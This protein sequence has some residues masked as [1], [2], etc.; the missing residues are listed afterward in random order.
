[1]MAAEPSALEKRMIETVD[2]LADA[3]PGS[4]RAMEVL[5][6]LDATVREAVDA[7]EAEAA[8]RETTGAAALIEAWSEEWSTQVFEAR[9]RIRALD[10]PH[11]HPA[12]RLWHA[13]A[14]SHLVDLPAP[15][16]QPAMEV[17]ATRVLAA[18]STLP[19]DPS[20]ETLGRGEGWE[21][22][23]SEDSHGQPGFLVAGIHDARRASFVREGRAM[24]PQANP[25]GLFC[26]TEPGQW[27]VRVD[28]LVTEVTV[29]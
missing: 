5:R 27:L 1:M 14:T 19:E 16:N 9:R 13:I 2:A 28:G 12:V 29:R 3:D 11:D 25:L 20:W 24:F 22:A 17:H 6:S 18:A 4:P 8:Y 21:L 15:A 10:L 7:G 26:P 23:F